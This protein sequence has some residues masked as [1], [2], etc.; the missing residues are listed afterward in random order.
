M[1]VIRPFRAL[2]PA[3]ERAESVASVPYDVV[4]TDE[5]RALA[6]GNPLSFLHVSRPE[7][8]LPPDTDIHSDAVYRKAVENFEKLISTCPLEKEAEPSLYL[9]RLIMGQH[10]QIGIVACC[11]VDEYDNSTIRKH[12]RTR[13]DKEDDRTRHMLMLRAQTGPVFL[14]YRRSAEIDEQVSAAISAEPLYD[15]TASDG[16]RHTIWRI[17]DTES[18]VKSFESVPLLYIADGHHRAASASRARAELRDQSF[19]HTGKEDYNYFLTV[20]FPDSQVQ[21]LAYNR[22][23]RDLNGLSQEAFL[24]EIRTQFTV[25]ENA[26]PEPERRGH[27]SMY[28]D[29]K[30]YG[31]QLSPAATLP[32]GTV[33]A[34]DVSVLQDR[35]LDPILGIKDVRTDKRVDFIGGL[36]GTKE[37]ERLVDEGK[38]AVAFSLYPTTVAELLMVSDANEIMPPKSTWFEPKLRDGLLIHSI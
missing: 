17:S 30:W 12:E 27:W 35:L 24:D 33:A 31:L 1:A 13:R 6:D 9:Y 11:A 34:L 10:E 22:T 2:R 20:I 29:G 38:A 21:I 8:D 3:A 28:L 25:T 19:G 16:V 14:T 4:N 37:L 18:L 36:R 26:S 32:S 15:L 5:A 23:V 7:I